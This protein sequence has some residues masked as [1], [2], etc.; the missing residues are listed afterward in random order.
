MGAA[1]VP[2]L[3]I[4][5]L[6]AAG[7]VAQKIS[8]ADQ[9]GYD[10]DVQARADIAEAKKLAAEEKAKQE[11]T[12]ADASAQ[13]KQYSDSQAMIAERESQSRLA[14]GRR[15]QTGTNTRSSVLTG[16]LGLSSGSVGYSAGRKTLLGS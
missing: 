10:A 4:G 7:G 15:S 9:V 11:K 5:S 2:L 14:R 16:P 3:T 13:Q 1:L 12:I 6:F 8:D